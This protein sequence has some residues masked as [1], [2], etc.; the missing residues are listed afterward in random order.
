MQDRRTRTTASVGSASAASG[1]SSTV[2]IPAA[3]WTA[4]RMVV[5]VPL[6]E[7]VGS[8][9]QG[10]GEGGQLVEVAHLVDPPPLL[11][12]VHDLADPGEDRSVE[13]AQHAVDLGLP[14]ADDEVAVDAAVLLGAAP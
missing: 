12:V 7:K 13:V 14:L 3:W 6:G 2:T 1:T 10:G 11:D 5:G 9:G 4:A 8:S